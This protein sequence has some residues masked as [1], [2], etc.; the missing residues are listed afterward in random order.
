MCSQCN[1]I[2]ILASLNHL[3]SRPSFRIF[4]GA[5]IFIC[6]LRDTLLWMFDL[7]V[8]AAYEHKTVTSFVSYRHAARCQGEQYHV[9]HDGWMESI[10]CDC[11]HWMCREN[12]IYTYI[13]IIRWRCDKNYQIIFSVKWPYWKCF[14]TTTD[15]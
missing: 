5:S 1:T 15:Y 2:K 9:G 4:W 11:L 3:D 12:K 10:T 8:I 6:R 7:W 14:L 13:E